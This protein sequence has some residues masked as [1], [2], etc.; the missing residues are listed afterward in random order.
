M[1][2]LYEKYGG[3]ETIAKV[4]DYFYD[5]VLEDESVNHFF[6]HT[7][8]VKQRGHQT[9]F[10]SFA[11]GGPNQ[12]SGGTMSKVHKGMNLQPAHYDAIVKHLRAALLHFGVTEEDTNIALKKIESLRGEILFQ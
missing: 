6:A 1:S 11:L 4:V 7:D 8:M 2:S 12:Y 10:V 5:L 3:E 9:K